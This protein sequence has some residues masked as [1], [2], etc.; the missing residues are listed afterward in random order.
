MSENINN[1]LIERKIIATLITITIFIVLPVWGIYSCVSESP[2]EIAEKQKKEIE[3]KASLKRLIGSEECVKQ[4][5][6]YP[7]SAEFDLFVNRLKLNDT[8]EIFEGKFEASNGFG[9]KVRKGFR[10]VV[11]YSAKYDTYECLGVDIL[12]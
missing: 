11:S 3:K 9:N 7:S 5:L 2:E 10:A 4:R 12:D 6:Q 1:T 8:T